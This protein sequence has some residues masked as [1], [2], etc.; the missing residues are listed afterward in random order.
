MVPNIHCILFIYNIYVQNGHWKQKKERRI[1]I[2]N[3]YTVYKVTKL[4]PY[5][6]LY[7]WFPIYIV[8]CLYTI[9][10]FKMYTETQSKKNDVGQ[11]QWWLS[12]QSS[13]SRY[14]MSVVR[15]QLKAKFK[16]KI[17]LQLTVDKTEINENE[18]GIAHLKGKGKKMSIHF[19]RNKS[20]ICIPNGKE[21]FPKFS[22]CP[23][24]RKNIWIRSNFI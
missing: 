14:Q 17:F 2:H 20:F 6:T 3:I 21:S 12:W 19:S 16:Q 24:I 5:I 11:R 15:I 18:A 4:K 8:Y 7:V 13:R 1:N 22:I 9:Y 23:F 10:M